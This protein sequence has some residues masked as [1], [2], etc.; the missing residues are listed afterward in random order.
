MKD[1]RK[2]EAL[3]RKKRLT[4]IMDQGHLNYLEMPEKDPKE[5]RRR[6]KW[7]RNLSLLR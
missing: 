6:G 2:K 7:V 1:R 4:L 5:W 3:E